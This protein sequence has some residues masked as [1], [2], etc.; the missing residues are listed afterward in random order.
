MDEKE[1]AEI[2][3]MMALK[4]LERRTN[5]LGEAL[6]GKK[7]R[8]LQ[9]LSNISWILFFWFFKMAFPANPRVWYLIVPLTVVVILLN[10][11]VRLTNLRVDALIKLI[12]EDKLRKDK[13]NLGSSD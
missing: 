9:T 13:N 12:G 3:G 5:L 10:G 4:G 11:Y 2:F 7:F 8:I 6:G 1:K